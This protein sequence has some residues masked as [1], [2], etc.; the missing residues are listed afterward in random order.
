[1]MRRTLLRLVP[2]AFLLAMP[3]PLSAQDAMRLVDEMREARGSDGFEIRMDVDTTSPDGARGEQIK[4]ALIGDGSDRRRR[5]LIRALAP[6]HLRGNSLVAIALDGR[7]DARAKPANAA[8]ARAVDPARALFGSALVA[9]DVLAPWWDW[10]D[11]AIGEREAVNGH[12][13]VEIRSRAPRADAGPVREVVSCVDA[14][15]ALAW[16]TR[17]LDGRGRELRTIVVVRAMRTQAGRS[18]ARSA[19]IDAADGSV[20]RLE[21]YAGDEHHSIAPG[22]FSNVFQPE[23]SGP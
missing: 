9:W 15:Q 2:C 1:M 10:T 19:V 14:E 11:Q 13:C 8:A 7:V 20:T 17:L 16:R 5:L 22:T 6:E 12:A 4:L 21:V 23:P 3:L 18:V